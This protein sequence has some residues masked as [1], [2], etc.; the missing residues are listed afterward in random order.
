MTVPK[1]TYVVNLPNGQQE[2]RK[3]LHPLKYAVIGNRPTTSFAFRQFGKTWGVFG[4][5]V[6]K[7]RAEKRMAD[8]QRKM[9][10]KECP[11]LLQIVE[12]ECE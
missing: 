9:S 3:S 8:M 7:D 11:F 10:V 1:K 4:W 5:H 12:V 6:T 2:E